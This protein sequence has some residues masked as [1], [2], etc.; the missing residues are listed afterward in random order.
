MSDKKLM[1]IILIR[2]QHPLRRH[3][4]KSRAGD[5]EHRHR[6]NRRQTID[7]DHGNEKLDIELKN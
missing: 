2:R 3:R 4:V 5:G 1:T 6:Q 7:I